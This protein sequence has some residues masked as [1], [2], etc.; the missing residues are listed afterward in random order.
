[1]HRYPATPVAQRPVKGGAGVPCRLGTAVTSLMQDD[2]SVTVAFSD[3]TSGAYDLVVGADG[4]RSTVRALTLGATPPIYLGAMNWR[5]I[6]PIVPRASK[7][8]CRCTSMMV[9]Y[10]GS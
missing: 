10:S 5:S 7:A 4:I 6:A 1:M 2:R 9:A 8:P 3:G